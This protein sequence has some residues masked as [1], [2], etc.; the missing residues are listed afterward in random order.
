[1]DPLWSKYIT[2][3]PYHYGLNNPLS[4]TD[5]TGLGVEDVNR[6]GAAVA[7][8]MSRM[9]EQGAQ[10]LA[11]GQGW[12][13]AAGTIL[14]ADGGA[15]SVAYE[16]FTRGTHA[17]AQLTTSGRFDGSPLLPGLA[18]SIHTHTSP[19]SEDDLV[20]R[21]GTPPG[22]IDIFS[23]GNLAVRFGDQAQGFISFIA[24]NGANFAVEIESVEQAVAFFGQFKDAKEFNAVFT[25]GMEG[26]SQGVRE[27]IVEMINSKKTG[28]RVYETASEDKSVYKEVK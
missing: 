3:T 7:G 25:K 14:R 18:G 11:S 5:F 4:L 15:I 19:E 12:G 28:V 23:T 20:P 8:Y 24:A 17:S 1:M 26:S 9:Y 22:G 16:T 10:Y 13:E 6:V 21:E 27:R 2:V